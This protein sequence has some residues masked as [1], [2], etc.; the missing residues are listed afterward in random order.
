M[1][2]EPSPEV[3]SSR[4]A[5]QDTYIHSGTPDLSNLPV[6]WGIQGTPDTKVMR[7]AGDAS[8]SCAVCKLPTIHPRHRDVGNHQVET[9]R[10]RPAGSQSFFTTIC[11]KD[12]VPG[13]LQYCAKIQESEG[14]IVDN[15][16]SHVTIPWA[17]WLSFRCFIRPHLI[18]AAH[19]PVRAI[20]IASTSESGAP[21]TVRSNSRS[22]RFRGHPAMHLLREGG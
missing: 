13:T 8:D 1:Q 2:F 5:S 16:D 20:Q 7:Q 17:P 21:Q 3:P 9:T 18:S 12:L 19:F 6:S 15:Q 14:L 4:M 22:R 11:E 10:S